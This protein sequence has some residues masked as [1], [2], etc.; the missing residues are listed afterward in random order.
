MLIY[1]LWE[2]IEDYQGC[3]ITTNQPQSYAVHNNSII[4]FVDMH[5]QNT[6]H[7][8]CIKNRQAMKWYNP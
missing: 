7:N 8:D 3:Y 4:W 2:R 5:P 1:V 6:S